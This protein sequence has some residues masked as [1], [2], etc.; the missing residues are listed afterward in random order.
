LHYAD[1]RVLSEVIG[2]WWKKLKL[3]RELPFM[4]DG[5]RSVNSSSN[6]SESNGKSENFAELQEGRDYELTAD[7]LLMFT[8]DYLR[9]RGYCCGSGCRNCP[10]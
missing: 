10:Y 8:A 1:F 3:Q 6:L 2:T 5:K 9:R 7:G 4:A